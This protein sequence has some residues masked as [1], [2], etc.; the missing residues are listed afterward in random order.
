VPRLVGPGA[1]HDESA[2][3]FE[4]KFAGGPKDWTRNPNDRSCYV[5][6]Q[7]NDDGANDQVE[8]KSGDIHQEIKSIATS[9]KQIREDGAKPNGGTVRPHLRRGAAPSVPPSIGRA[10]A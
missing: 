10:P 2:Q 7:V 9:L 4:F 6:R 1:F 5:T 8:P 3:T